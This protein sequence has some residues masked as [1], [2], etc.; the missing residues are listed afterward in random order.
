MHVTL[1][2]GL[3]W[4]GLSVL[5]HNTSIYGGATII[6]ARSSTPVS[7]DVEEVIEGRLLKSGVILK[8]IFVLI[9][10]YA[11][12]LAVDSLAFWVHYA[13]PYRA[14]KVMNTHFLR[15]ILI[16]LKSIWIEIMWNPIWSLVGGSSSLL[17]RIT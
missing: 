15:E 7:F 8:M 3:E 2:N 1:V 17:K 11:P 9:L 12:S 10:V 14:V 4:H 6:Y 13:L 16:L 5:S